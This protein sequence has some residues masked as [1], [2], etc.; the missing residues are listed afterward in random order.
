MIYPKFLYIIPLSDW[1]N[2]IGFTRVHPL[3]FFGLKIIADETLMNFWAKVTHLDP[4]LLIESS[5]VFNG[6]SLRKIR[7]EMLSDEHRWK[8]WWILGY[9]GQS[10]FFSPARTCAHTHT[11]K[12]THVRA[13]ARTYTYT[14]TYI[15]THTYRHTQIHS[16]AHTHTYIHTH[17]QTHKR[18]LVHAHTHTNT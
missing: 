18:T 8:C 7:S 12:Y 6:G 1:T 16:C 2:F 3:N 17:T 11:H 15:H 13:H 4:Y 5:S 9:C 14:Y 10:S